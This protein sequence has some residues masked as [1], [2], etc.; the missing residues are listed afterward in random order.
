M[1]LTEIVLSGKHPQRVAVMGKG[2]KHANIY[3]HSHCHRGSLFYLVSSLEL[4]VIVV[5]LFF[6]SFFFVL[7]VVLVVLVIVV[8]VIV[9]V[10][11]VSVEEIFVLVLFRR[12]RW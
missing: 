10:S 7:V 3:R 4:F 5:V 6:F 1:G 9:V 2:R 8:L 11:V 12:R